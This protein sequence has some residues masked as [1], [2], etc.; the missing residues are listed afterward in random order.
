MRESGLF[1]WVQPVEIPWQ[2]T[3]SVDDFVTD[4]SSHSHVAAQPAEDREELLGDLRSGLLDAFPDGVAE[5]PYVT[6]VWVSRR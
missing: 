4:Q 6:R 1:G 2:R 3:V 5:L